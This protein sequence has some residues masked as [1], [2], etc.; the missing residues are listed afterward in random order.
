MYILHIFCK[1]T[2]KQFITPALCLSDR[3]LR[4]C[5]LVDGAAKVVGRD[6]EALVLD[7]SE[8]AL[9]EALSS[10]ESA[11]SETFHNSNAL[12]FSAVEDVT[13]IV[14]SYASTMLSSLC[15]SESLVE[16]AVNLPST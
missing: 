2:E 14:P 9:T 11:V 13:A 8:N 7:C 6:D 15:Q 3:A 16:M 10:S 5:S 4:Q 1:Q 12:N